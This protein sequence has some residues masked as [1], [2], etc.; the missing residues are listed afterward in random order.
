M[1]TLGGSYAKMILNLL[2]LLKEA[3]KNNAENGG[4]HDTVGIGKYLL[5]IGCSHDEKGGSCEGP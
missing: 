2:I 1:R 5:T 4:V 3:F